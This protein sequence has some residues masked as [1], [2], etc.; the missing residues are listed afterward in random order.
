MEKMSDRLKKLRKSKGLSQ[1][2]VGNMVGVAWQNI[3][4]IET[5]KV[6]RPRYINELAE[7][8]ETSVGYLLNGQEKPDVVKIREHV[9]MVGIDTAVVP[10]KDCDFYIIKIKKEE[11][12]FLAENCELVGKVNRIFISHVQ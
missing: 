12:L 11:K 10:E 9:S 8:L 7:A 2:A 4:N 1:T 6:V 3:Q 5:G